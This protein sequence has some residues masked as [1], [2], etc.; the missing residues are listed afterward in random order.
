MRILVVE[1]ERKMAD[2]IRKGL[3]REHHTVM[4]THTGPDGLELALGYPFDAMV[5]DVMVPGFDGFEL[6]RRLRAA[7]NATPILFLTARD[8]EEDLIK[9]L[10]EGGDDYLTKP[11]SFREFTAR[12]RALT[13]RAPQTTA[14]ILKIADITLDRSTH[15][16]AR[17]GRNIVLTRTEYSLLEFFM[18]HPG[19]V[20]TRDV[21]I[22][23]IWGLTGSIESN[24]LD[25]FIKLLRQK[26]DNDYETKLLHTVRGFG[27][28]F[29]GA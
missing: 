23:A 1:D 24:T 26:V 20:L 5:L 8:T 9:G 28:R 10:D 29:G 21:L 19:H 22:D 2:L 27:Y 7:G 14:T 25:T 12:L 13:R 4:T 17:G 3:E 6:A 15:G 11:F 16:V 18:R